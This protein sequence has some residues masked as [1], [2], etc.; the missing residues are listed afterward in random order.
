MGKKTCFINS[1][2][3]AVSGVPNDIKYCFRSG[4]AAI[5]WLQQLKERLIIELKV[6]WEK[7]RN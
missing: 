2:R 6:L 4:I 7:E 5:K 1:L 3:R